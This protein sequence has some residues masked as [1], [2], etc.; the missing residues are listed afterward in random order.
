MMF[1]ALV[2]IFIAPAAVF[3]Q[4]TIQDREQ[5]QILNRQIRQQKV[6]V[7]KLEKDFAAILSLRM[8]DESTGEELDRLAKLNDSTYLSPIEERRFRELS[9]KEARVKNEL[10][11]KEIENPNIDEELPMAKEKLNN[12]IDQKS[13]ILKRAATNSAVPTEIGIREEKLRNRGFAVKEKDADL[14]YKINLQNEAL[15]RLTTNSIAKEESNETAYTI[16]LKNY[17]KNKKRQFSVK[18]IEGTRSFILEPGEVKKIS[19]LPQKYLCDIVDIESRRASYGNYANVGLQT[20]EIEG[21]K[22]AGFFYA[23]KYF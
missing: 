6:L 14:N 9:K 19:A 2:A 17:S 3:S 1:L 16:V 8:I 20:Q 18:G 23:P 11:K 7:K 10:S 12:L 21:I 22:C 4:L 15:R 13:S 5:M